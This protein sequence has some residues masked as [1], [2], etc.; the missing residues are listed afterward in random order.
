LYAQRL[1]YI[2]AAGI[3]GGTEAMSGIAG[4]VGAVPRIAGSNADSI[5][6][7]MASSLE[8]RGPDDQ[9]I[10]IDPD[11]DATLVHRRLSIIDLSPAGHQPMASAGVGRRHF[12]DHFWCK[13]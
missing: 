11:A 5:A 10:W 2:D 1:N 3:R 4:F 9:G 7:A 6:Q 12:A 8:H 13:L